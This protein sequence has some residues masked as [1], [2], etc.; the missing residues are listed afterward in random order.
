M[1]ISDSTRRMI[2]NIILKVRSSKVRSRL[3]PSKI[4]NTNKSFYARQAPTPHFSTKSSKVQSNPTSSEKHRKR[5]S[6]ADTVRRNHPDSSAHSALICACH[7]RERKTLVWVQTWTPSE[8]RRK[9]SHKIWSAGPFPA[10]C[11]RCHCQGWKCTRLRQDRIGKTLVGEYQIYHS[12]KKGKCVVYTTSI[13][14]LSNQ[15]FYDLKHQFKG[16]TVEI[17]T[18][19]IKFCPDAQIVIM[20][21]EILRNLLATESL[22]L[23]ASLSMD[24][25]NAVVFDEG[26]YINNFTSSPQRASV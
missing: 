10:A 15:K 1:K 22:G 21:T 19:D 18:G 24:D 25:V 9:Q 6:I 5:R 14:S 13:K 12:L 26:H 2:A 17:M 20:T 8:K 23:T 4:L 7:N 16:A 3:N 11:C